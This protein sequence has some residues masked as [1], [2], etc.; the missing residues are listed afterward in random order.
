MSDVGVSRR[1]SVTKLPAEFCPRCGSPLESTR[2]EGRDRR[3]CEACDRI[4]FQQPGVAANVAV[5]DGED[6]LLVQRGRPP[7]EGSWALPGGAVEHDEPLA[8]AAARELREETNV[9][10]SPVD[11][12]PFDTW[13]SDFSDGVYAVA[14]GF[15][16]SRADTAGEP[17]AGS[18]AADARFRRLDS[19]LYEDLRPGAKARTRRAI[20]A[21]E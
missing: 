19:G 18:D 11:L 17:A 9:E 7:H 21:V 1:S 8:V 10:A 13:Q 3:Y 15:V 14:V 12:V 2:F 20:E 16:V 5:V 6:V 4:V